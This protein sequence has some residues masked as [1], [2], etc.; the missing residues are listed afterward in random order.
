[1]E[2]ACVVAGSLEA[3]YHACAGRRCCRTLSYCSAREHRNICA[4][5][6]VLVG[7]KSHGRGQRASLGVCC[8]AGIVAAQARASAVCGTVGRALAPDHRAPCPTARA[9]RSSSLAVTRR[10]YCPARSEA[11]S[12]R[13]SILAQ[14]RFTRR[15]PHPPF[16]ASSCRED[17]HRRQT[18]TADHISAGCWPQSWCVRRH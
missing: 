10:R 6:C 2:T 14:A 11:M 5:F 18:H 15:P 8:G 3:E 7:V 13:P 17:L 4:Q 12:L 9:P 16:D 1:M